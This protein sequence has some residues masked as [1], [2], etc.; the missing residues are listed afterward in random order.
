VGLFLRIGLQHRLQPVIVL[1]YIQKMKPSNLGDYLA[2]FGKN[3][4]RKII[5]TQ[6]EAC[7]AQQ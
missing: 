3:R 2:S 1:G 4:P 6:A 5:R 7:A